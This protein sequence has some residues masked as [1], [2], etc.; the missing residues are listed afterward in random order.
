MWKE[1]VEVVWGSDQNASGTFHF[2]D[3]LDM[4]YWEADAE[5]TGEIIYPIWPG[6]NSG[7]HRRS[8]RS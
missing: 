1:P 5:H 3:V 2:G 8:L 7:S 4:S 6:N